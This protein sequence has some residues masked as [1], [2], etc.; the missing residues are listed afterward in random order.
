MTSFYQNIFG[1]CDFE[2][3]YRLAVDTY[4][5][6]K[7]IEVGS[8]QG[9]SA[10]YLCEYIKSQGKDIKVICV[11]AWPDKE[12][13]EKFEDKGIGQGAEKEE[14][15]KLPKS[16]YDT[17]IENMTN[18]GVMNYIEPHRGFSNEIAKELSHEKYAMVFIDASHSYSGCMSDLELYWPLVQEKGLMM[19]HDFGCEG[20]N[21][22]VTEF[23][24]KLN[25]N[26]ESI[27]GSWLVRK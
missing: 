23:F 18:A 13:L 12:D 4:D 7:F 6:C 9:R 2:D 15:N 11:D 8:F 25:I 10:C 26:V 14:I 27:K 19:G 17:F 3:L 20:V 22:A 5:H 16:L 21:K 1:W 24:G